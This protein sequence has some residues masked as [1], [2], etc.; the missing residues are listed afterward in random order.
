MATRTDPWAPGTRERSRRRL[1]GGA[2]LMHWDLINAG[3]WLRD[4]EF[5]GRALCVVP[6][7]PGATKAAA[8]LLLGPGGL[9]P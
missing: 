5:F 2:A 3:G 8:G 1:P 6:G 7:G 4:Q 9:D